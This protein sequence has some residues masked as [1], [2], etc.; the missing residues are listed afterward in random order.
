VLIFAWYRRKSKGV[1]RI[2]PARTFA[3]AIF[4]DRIFRV[5]INVHAA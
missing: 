4:H 1:G 2:K 3:R 5:K